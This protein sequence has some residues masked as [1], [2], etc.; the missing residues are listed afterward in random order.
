MEQFEFETPALVIAA[1]WSL[2][3][4]DLSVTLFLKYS[5]LSRQICSVFGVDRV[6]TFS[7]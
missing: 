1:R 7:N 2:V 6:L 5:S 4:S 3:V